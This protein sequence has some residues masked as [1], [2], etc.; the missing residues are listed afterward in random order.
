LILAA[1]IALPLPCF[2]YEGIPQVQKDAIRESFTKQI[3]GSPQQLTTLQPDVQLIRD[4][5]TKA[6]EVDYRE[7]LPA[8]PIPWAQLFKQADMQLGQLISLVGNA[9]GYDSYFDPRVNLSQI[10]KL[11]SHPNSLADIAEYVTR[12]TDS[13]ITLYPETRSITVTLK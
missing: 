2:A 1:L 7:L 10:V 11:N 12:V 13:R 5:F 6:N 9:A 8:D 4:I 3:L